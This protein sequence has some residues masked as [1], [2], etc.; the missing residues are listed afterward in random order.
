MIMVDK[1]LKEWL[2]EERGRMSALARFL[3]VHYSWISHIAE[4]RRRAPL[5]TAIQIAEFTNNEVSIT[6]IA[7]AYH[8]RKNKFSTHE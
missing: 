7:S 1:T 2:K 8:L 5:E 4:G 3:N 6:N